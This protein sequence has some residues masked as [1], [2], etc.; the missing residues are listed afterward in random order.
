[1]KARDMQDYVYARLGFRKR[2]VPREKVDS[3]VEQAIRNWPCE[4]LSQCKEEDHYAEI[5][6]ANVGSLKRR[7]RSQNY[8]FV[9]TIILSALA[10]AVIDILIRWWLEKRANRVMM[11]VWRQE[12]MR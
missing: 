10:S 6:K 5:R 8:G 3:L 2:L 1:M 7:V 12:A 11:M 9:W 4:A